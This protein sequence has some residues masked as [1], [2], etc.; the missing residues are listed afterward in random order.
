MKHWLTVSLAI[1]LPTFASA[2]EIKCKVNANQNGDYSISLANKK[3]SLNLDQV[4]DKTSNT[5]FQPYPV[6]LKFDEQ[7]SLGRSDTETGKIKWLK[8]DK[9][10]SKDLIFMG[11]ESNGN[12]VTLAF[13]KTSKS[14][15]IN[16]IYA[17]SN[18][19]SL[20][21]ITEFGKCD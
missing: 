12:H 6:T 18:G 14:L 21:T 2:S 8:L 17:P 1:L 13:D 10:A 3:V 20:G 15:I 9:S 11:V 5:Y 19:N 7:L 16:T 4:S